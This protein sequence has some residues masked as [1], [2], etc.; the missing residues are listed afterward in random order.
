MPTF[1]P[2]KMG[3]LILTAAWNGDTPKAVEI[4]HVDRGATPSVSS[5]ITTFGP[6]TAAFTENGGQPPFTLRDGQLRV[7]RFTLPQQL[8]GD[9]SSEVTVVVRTQ[10]DQ[11]STCT[12]T[13]QIVH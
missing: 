7:D 5:L 4:H 8:V 12:T 10:E 1:A 6:S 9:G 13:I 3:Q 11:E 2:G